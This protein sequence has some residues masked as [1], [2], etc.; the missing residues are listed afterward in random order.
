M[1]EGLSWLPPGTPEV[2]LGEQGVSGH[3]GGQG[4]GCTRSLTQLTA[5]GGGQIGQMV[6]RRLRTRHHSRPQGAAGKGQHPLH[7][8]GAGGAWW[9][10]EARLW[11][12]T[13]EAGLCSVPAVSTTQRPGLL[14]PPAPP[15][16]SAQALVPPL[17]L[18]HPWSRASGA[19]L[20]PCSVQC[21]R[22]L[23][24]RPQLWGARGPGPD[25]LPGSEELVRLLATARETLREKKGVG[26]LWHP[27]T[28]VYIHV[29]LYLTSVY[30]YV[31]PRVSHTHVYP[32]T[33]V[34]LCVYSCTPVHRCV[35][36]HTCVY[37]CTP[38]HAHGGPPHPG[39]PHLR[40]QP[41]VG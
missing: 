22:P 26:R 5:V 18:C 37:P 27:W 30:I 9:V 23:R 31:H 21:A 24:L 39:I 10:E 12:L 1:E 11:L 13:Q 2:R 14:P 19:P 35:Y 6:P 8:Q 33:S 36:L 7:A 32:L 17:S 25:H 41:T 20:S 38:A 16:A 29:Y 3:P 40:I 28:A 15:A 4:R 34:C